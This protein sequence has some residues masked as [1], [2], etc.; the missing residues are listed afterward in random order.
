MF[1]NGDVFGL[2]AYSIDAGV[3]W[4]FDIFAICSLPSPVC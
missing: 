1:A 3:F 4:L 2:R